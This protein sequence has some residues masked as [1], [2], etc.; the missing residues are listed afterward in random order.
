MGYSIK[1][2]SNEEFEKLPYRHTDIALGLADP[3]Q[4]TA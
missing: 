3:K 2:L 4:N 1:V